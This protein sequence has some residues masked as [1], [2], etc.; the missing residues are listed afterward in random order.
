[1]SKKKKKGEKKKK[2]KKKPKEGQITHPSQALFF[3]SIWG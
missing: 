2:E 1:L 3:T